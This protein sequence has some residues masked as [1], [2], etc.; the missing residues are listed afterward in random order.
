MSEKNQMVVGVI[1][2]GTVST[3]R[4]CLK[5]TD[6]RD[7]LHDGRCLCRHSRTRDEPWIDI[8]GSGSC[9]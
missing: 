1:N 4:Q 2:F 6:Y 5:F 3:G 7:F 8:I 9:L